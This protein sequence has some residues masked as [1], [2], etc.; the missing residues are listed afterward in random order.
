MYI[1][2]NKFK[3]FNNTPSILLKNTF[4]TTPIFN[5]ILASRFLNIEKSM[6][7]DI[8]KEIIEKS[9]GLA[10]SKKKKHGKKNRLFTPTKEIKAPL[11]TKTTTRSHAKMT[12]DGLNTLTTIRRY[13][14]AVMMQLLLLSSV[15]NGS[16]TKVEEIKTSQLDV[17]D[18]YKVFNQKYT[19][20]DLLDLNYMLEIDENRKK[21]NNTESQNTYQKK[22]PFKSTND[23]KTENRRRLHEAMFGEQALKN[24]QDATKK[25]YK[26]SLTNRRY[27]SH[28]KHR[29][30]LVEKKLF[31]E[32]TCC[33]KANELWETSKKYQNKDINKAILKLKASLTALLSLNNSKGQKN[34]TISNAK[35]EKLKDILFNIISFN[36]SR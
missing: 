4:K 26:K 15:I 27:S 17:S 34:K 16:S 28:K 12:I 19:P 3:S 30:R 24:Q 21:Y 1:I 32:E 23:P 31:Y 7:R 33:S 13:G 11:P 6:L 35:K 18:P 14:P 29:F 36:E 5:L 8:N 10:D 9:F 20:D 22:D 25:L 2:N